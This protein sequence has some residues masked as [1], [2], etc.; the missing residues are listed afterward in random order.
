MTYFIRKHNN[1]F[2]IPNTV[3]NYF[4]PALVIKLTGMSNVIRM[5]VILYFKF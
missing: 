5:V 4:L 2:Y 3:S 1:I